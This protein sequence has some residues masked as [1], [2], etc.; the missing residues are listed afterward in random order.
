[1]LPLSSYVPTTP[2]KSQSR[3]YRARG[4]LMRNGCCV[5]AL[6]ALNAAEGYL[7]GR[8]PTLQVAALCNGSCIAYVRAGVTVLKADD[9][10]LVTRVLRGREPLL[11]AAASVA[12]A[13]IMVETF[14]KASGTERQMFGRMAGP[15]EVFDDTVAT[16]LDPAPPPFAAAAG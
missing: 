15:T 6:R 3:S 10:K 11:K 9:P 1:M 2:T 4:R 7:Q 12:N 16:A 5:A 14:R 13:V 8:F